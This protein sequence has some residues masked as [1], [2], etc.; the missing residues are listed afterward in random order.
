MALVWTSMES[1]KG[2]R[3]ASSLAV[4]IVLAL[5]V[6]GGCESPMELDVDR[7]EQYMDGSVHPTR[8]SLYY[9][10]GDSAYEAIVV[11]TSFLNTIW[12]SKGTEPWTITIPQFNFT[13][14]D[15]MQATPEH[16]PLVREFSFSIEN[17]RVDGFFRS[18]INTNC[19]LAG[20]YLD[21]MKVSHDFRWYSNILDKQILLAWF[22]PEGQD[23]VKGRMAIR[24]INPMNPSDTVTYNGLFT[25]EF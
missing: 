13:L 16:S 5:A 20:A 23:L 21:Q 4:L 6:L 15:S 8:L 3:H 17:Q 7:T 25:V 2:L 12:I 9:Y 11:D 14:S 10:F 1:S 18:C 24:I 19:W 22:R